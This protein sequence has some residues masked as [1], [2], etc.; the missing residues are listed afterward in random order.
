MS[1]AK[2]LDMCADTVLQDKLGLLH[3]LIYTDR[4]GAVIGMVFIGALL[5]TR[6]S[7]IAISIA[8]DE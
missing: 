5:V 7:V 8:S 2:P 4:R 1:E 6:V 3:G